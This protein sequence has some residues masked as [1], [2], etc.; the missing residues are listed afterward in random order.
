MGLRSPSERSA[1]TP[2]SADGSSLSLRFIVSFISPSGLGFLLQSFW[3]CAR[4]SREGLSSPREAVRTAAGPH[5]RWPVFSGGRVAFPT[6][7]VWDRPAC[8]GIAGPRSRTRRHRLL[9]VPSLLQEKAQKCRN[10]LSEAGTAKVV[11]GALPFPVV[12]SGS[13]RNSVWDTF[14]KCFVCLRVPPGRAAH[15]SL[16]SGAVRTRPVPARP[17][18]GQHRSP[19]TERPARLQPLSRKAATPVPGA[20]TGP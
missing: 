20:S 13:H 9:R 3:D 1:A 7:R 8:G 17:S 6:A 16:P 18:D 14:E 4:P 11:F 19:Q 10:S 12:N 15:R 2:P 5:A